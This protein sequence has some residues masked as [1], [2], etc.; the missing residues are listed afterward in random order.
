MQSSLF[1]NRELSW[2][3]FN[4]RVLVEAFDKTNPLFEK[5][6]FLSITASNLD[7]FFMI[8]VSGV[9][10]QME[11]NLDSV[12]SSGMTAAQQM[13]MIS[14]RTHEL[15]KKQY[16]CLFRSIIPSLEKEGITFLKMEQLDEEQK[17][18]I[19]NY[20]KQNIFPVLTPMA[21]DQSRPFPLLLNKSLNLI[22][23][24][25]PDNTAEDK[26]LIAFV[27][28]PSV[29][30]RIVQL[31]DKKRNLFVYLEDIMEEYISDLF[32]G[33][34]LKNVHTFRITRNSDLEIDEEEAKDFL[35]EIEK[36]IKRRKWGFPVRLEV[37]KDI[38][39]KLKHFLMKKLDLDDEDVYELSNPIDLTC[40]MKFVSLKGFE[41]L[42]YK[43]M[44]PVMQRDL[45]KNQNIFDVIKEKDVLVYHPFH[46]F[47][48]VVEFVD[49]A[50]QD[51][52]V[53]AIKQTLYRVSGD[54]PIVK[55]LIKAAENG[56]QVTVIVEL[57]ARFDEENNIQWA[58]KLERSGCHV[59]YGLVGLKTHCKVILIVRRE[60]DGIRRYVHMGT[61]N[62]N[63]STAK[64][65]TDTGLFTCKETYGSDVSSLFN[66]LTGYSKAPQ[67]KKINVAPVGLREGFIELIENE[68]N[69]VK[70]GKNGYM[71]AKV[72]AV[73]DEKIIEK[74][75]EASCAGV[76]IDLIVRGICCLRP[77][78]KGVSENIRVI[79]IVGRLLE[80]SRIFYINNGGDP[81][82]CMS[83]ADWMPRNL[84]RRVET[85]FPVEQA[86][87]IEEVKKVLDIILSDTMKARIQK[88]D[89]TY[90]RIDK[91][92]K[93]HIDSQAE[94]F[95][96]YEKQY[97]LSVQEE[98]YEDAVPFINRG[99]E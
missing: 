10:E 99:A 95:R 38:S 11:D 61:G 26:E 29:L 47:D 31:E 64:I 82:V 52:N 16:N 49:K 36:S 43:P 13:K 77:G 78:L 80:H 68:I 66:V 23:L 2:L 1:I 72:N 41:K 71:I 75:Y 96:Y 87:L 8:R 65:Y 53:L 89:G 51:P 14:Q 27:Q 79:S 7:E 34:V 98:I 39:G 45:T 18:F 93:E 59:V 33:Y 3:E 12:D 4:D 46:T 55:A 32:P 67:W 70:Q 37:E 63:D 42:R 48:H 17:K 15:V 21:V 6:K 81:K 88:S 19:Y 56:K 5:L 90:S 76:K 24:L 40:W 25:E 73:V 86:N 20:F 94:L 28:V 91:R 85:L 60:E 83:S 35:I 57:R 84:D 92:G 62:Y 74:L 30:P 54:S 58:K 22:V 69:M 97:E 44:Q 9:M 50:A